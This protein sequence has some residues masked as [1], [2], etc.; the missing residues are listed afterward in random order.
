MNEVKLKQLDK[1][2][3][4]LINLRSTY[5]L[6]IITITGG[7]IGILYNFSTLNKILLIAGI[8]SDIYFF[9]LLYNI[10]NQIHKLI[11]RM[12]LYS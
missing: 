6:I 5:F 9:F 3:D 10:T 2:I 11:K 1:R 7:I 8:V 4:N 12:E